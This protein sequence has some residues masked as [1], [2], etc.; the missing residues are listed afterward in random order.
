VSLADNI[1]LPAWA[2]N[3]HGHALVEQII[4]ERPEPSITRGVWIEGGGVTI[5]RATSSADPVAQLRRLYKDWLDREISAL[6]AK[7]HATREWD[8]EASNQVFRTEDTD[9]LITRVLR[10]TENVVPYTRMSIK[11]RPDGSAQV[12]A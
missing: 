1:A 8:Q 12:A 7:Y 9:K 6:D 3:Q 4:R 5:Y 10:E 2:L 11:E